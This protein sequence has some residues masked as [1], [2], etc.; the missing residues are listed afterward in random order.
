MQ[1]RDNLA[2]L[3]LAGVV[4]LSLTPLMGVV[5]AQAQIAFSSE[6][7]GTGKST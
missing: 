1:C 3:I 4:V 6:R 7:E 5:D 2:H